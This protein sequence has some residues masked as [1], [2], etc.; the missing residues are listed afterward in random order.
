MVEENEN[1]IVHT[2][3][4]PKEALPKS[5][6]SKNYPSKSTVYRRAKKGQESQ[7]IIIYKTGANQN[8]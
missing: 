4:F 8:G 2:F 5:W 1:L 6:I 3:K 7:P